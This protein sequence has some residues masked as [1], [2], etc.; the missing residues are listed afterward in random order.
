MLYHIKCET[1]NSTSEIIIMLFRKSSNLTLLATNSN[2]IVTK[3]S[4][5][6][7]PHT[8]AL[9][10]ADWLQMIDADPEFAAILS[11]LNITKEYF[12]S[13]TG[14]TEIDLVNK[15]ISVGTC[16]VQSNYAGMLYFYDPTL[17]VNKCAQELEV[18]LPKLITHLA[19]TRFLQQLRPYGSSIFVERLDKSF[20]GQKYIIAQN[21]NQ[22]PDRIEPNIRTRLIHEELSAT[23]PK[24]LQNIDSYCKLNE[25]DFPMI[26]SCNIEGTIF[27]N[28]S[29]TGHHMCMLKQGSNFV[30]LDTNA[31]CLYQ[32]T[33]ELIIQQLLLN[34]LQDFVRF[35][36]MTDKNIFAGPIEYLLNQVIFHIYIDPVLLNGKVLLEDESYTEK[37]ITATQQIAALL[38]KYINSILKEHMPST[39]KT[40]KAKI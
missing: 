40:F 9:T 11:E 31:A 24:F 16:T 37:Q 29:S 36:A 10:S 27:N 7:K 6:H 21:Y 8:I 35:W 17:T 23:L 33:L 20:Y 22:N 4:D 2:P 3:L 18:A 32:G 28:A 34:L 25:Q 39:G 38:D 15:K 13:V 14:K 12:D 30:L 1:K 19:K 26:I 5:I